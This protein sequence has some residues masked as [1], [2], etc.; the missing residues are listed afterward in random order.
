MIEVRASSW[1]R[2]FDCA[3]AWEGEH[4]LNL[5]RPSG[6]RASLGTAVHASTAVFDQSRIDGTGITASD[7]A[8]VFV[9]TLHNPGGDVDYKQDRSITMREAEQIGLTLH[10]KYCAEISPQF[11]FVAVEMKM[12]PVDIDC[13]DGITLRLKGTMDRA[14]V[15]RGGAGGVIIPDI[16]TGSR[17]IDADGN[18]LIKGRSPQ[19]GAYAI[20]FEQNTRTP[21]EGS[22]IIALQTTASART[23]VSKTFDAKRPMLGTSYEDGLIAHAVQF[24]KSGMFPPNPSSP[25]CDPRFCG[26]WDS[27]IYRDA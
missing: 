20:M 22:Q 7:A 3:Y 8:D 26:R 2:L 25:L 11:E 16:K 14:R 9:A 6:I 21:T 4:L 5:K 24:L 12:E 27:C 18:V 13:G 10:A 23:G 19:L 15:A 17:L 1:G